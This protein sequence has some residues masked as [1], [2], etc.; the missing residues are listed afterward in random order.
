M[1]VSIENGK[2]SF[3]WQELLEHLSP[4]EIR[5]LVDFLSCE[6]QIIADVSAQL[7]D[8]W[9][10]MGSH[11]Y[12]GMASV[13][14]FT[15]LEKARREIALRAGETAKAEIE[16]LI[17]ALKMAKAG[18]AR[19]SDWGFKL[20]NILNRLQDEHIYKGQVPCVMRIELCELERFE[21]V[22]KQET[23]CK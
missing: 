15:P 1:K 13:E 4:E 12:K 16:D 19:Y 6:N 5:E 8:G 14:P 9:T 3:K 21:V 17:R 11:G 22:R 10:E 2:I 7:L 20:Y 23:S 18:E